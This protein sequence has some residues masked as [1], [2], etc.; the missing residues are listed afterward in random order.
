MIDKNKT[1]TQLIRELTELRQRITELEKT[2]CDKITGT[3][4]IIRD[5]SG[6]KQAEELLRESEERF[7]HFFEN[8]PE[9][10][11][12][13]SPEGTILDVNKAALRALS[14]RKKEL[15]GKPLKMIYAAE[16]HPK[17]KRLFAKWE[18]SG[19]L[20]DEELIVITKKG[21]KRTVLLSVGAVRDKHGA[22]LH[23]ISVQNDITAR[24]YAEEALR[25]REE[26]YRTLIEKQGEGIAIVDLEERFTFCNP[27]AEEIFGVPHG[28]LVGRSLRE[29][30]SPDMFDVVRKQTARR[31]E[32]EK[33]TYELVITRTDGEKRHLLATA[34]PRYDEND[35]LVGSFGIFRDETKSKRAEEALRE[36]EAR[37]RRLLEETRGRLRES[38]TLFRV[39]QTL[40][41]VI[42]LSELLKEIIDS[43]VEIIGP[44]EKGVIHIFDEASG[45]LEP[46]ALS[47]K[48]IG[49]LRGRKMHIG[50]GIAGHALKQ[51]SAISVPDVNAES[52][53]LKLGDDP[54]FNSLL[55]IPLILSRKRIGTL[56]VESKKVNAFTGEDERLLAT[57]GIQAAIAIEN[58]RLY[59]EARKELNER[60]RAEEALR[61]SEKK[62]RNLINQ[63]HDAIYLLYDGKFEIINK[64]FE[65]LFGYTQDETNSPD[66]NF[67]NLVASR[68]RNLIEERVVKVEK[69]EYVSP[70]YEFTALSR[71]GKE[72]EVETSVSYI[73]YKGSLATQGI[74]RDITERKKTEETI[75]QMAYHDSLTGLPNRK[76]FA[77]RLT[78]T[79]A[80]AHRKRQML[81]VMFFD[82]DRF[83][84][85][86]D[87][88]GHTEGD[89]LLIHVSE[90]LKNLLRESDTVGRMGGDEFLL[91]LP[92][93]AQRNDAGE[94]AQKI[95]EAIRMPFVFH[96]R[97]LCITTSIGVAIYPDDGETVDTLIKKADIAM[98]HAKKAGRDNYKLYSPTMTAE[99]SP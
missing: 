51:G 85:I 73:Q 53:F 60:K 49:A 6:R 74:L 1:K 4:G 86:N 47:R 68:S 82:L 20:K 72:I 54:G 59:D 8:G 76:L 32:G 80:L 96:N 89:Q 11:Y 92:D 35:L 57:L 39:S 38:E 24:K 93:I 43:A 61:E 44:A 91:L 26:L 65:E 3:M 17:M 95:V 2:E 12:M 31:R 98:Y 56:S 69:G 46:M 81:S 78:H 37:F 63:S 36:S 28:K 22:I 64:R 83:K 58:A 45:R 87:K 40:A 70:Q 75:R 27:V 52:R 50:E 99:D 48:T 71:D 21:D 13:I 77:D 5:I 14:Y 30:V 84:N 97:E 55:A 25:E 79:M 34:I 42:D 10:Y 15:I 66:F 7:R 67:M 94:I 33:S 19:S 62:Y 29:F 9:Y 90:R 23:S 88:F 18:K 16:S 41:S